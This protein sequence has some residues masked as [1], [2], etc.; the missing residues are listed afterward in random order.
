M[1]IY[2][3]ETRT[4]CTKPSV[5]PMIKSFKRKP[6]HLTSI[7]F[8]NSF[9]PPP[10]AWQNFPFPH[11]NGF[12]GGGGGVAL[13]INKKGVRT[14]YVRNKCIPKRISFITGTVEVL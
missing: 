12:C 9:V 11:S 7:D 1:D 8:P 4:V 10:I 6:S 5:E 13:T 3:Q 2:Y 14:T